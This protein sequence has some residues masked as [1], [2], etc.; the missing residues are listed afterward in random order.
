MPLLEARKKE[1][2][3]MINNYNMIKQKLKNAL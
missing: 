3:T 1:Y 2:E